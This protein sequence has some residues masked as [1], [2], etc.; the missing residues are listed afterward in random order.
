MKSLQK[1]SSC[2]HSDKTRTGVDCVQ[3]GLHEKSFHKQ[4]CT[5]CYKN[6]S[7]LGYTV[8]LKSTASN[9]ITTPSCCCMCALKS[10]KCIFTFL[11]SLHC[12]N[13]SQILWQHASILVKSSWTV[14]RSVMVEIFKS[15]LFWKDL[16]YVYAYRNNN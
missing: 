6:R 5:F 13:V 7:Y 14:G 15:F 3:V 1:P 9:L 4:Y 16:L 8:N 12:E 2:F 11:H 10:I